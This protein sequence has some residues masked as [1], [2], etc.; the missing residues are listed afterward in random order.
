MDIF[1]EGRGFDNI[2]ALGSN[3]YPKLFIR[4]YLKQANGETQ[5]FDY[6]GTSMWSINALIRADFAGI[7]SDLSSIPIMD[8]MRPIVTNT[9]YYIRFLHELASVRE[10][11]TPLFRARMD[12]RVARFKKLL[13]D[14]ERIL[15]VRYQENA[16]GRIVYHDRSN[17]EFEEIGIFI[18]LVKSTYGCKNVSVIY[19]NLEQEGWNAT[20]D[21][22]SVKIDSLKHDHK[23]VPATI[24]SVLNEH[25]LIF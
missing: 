21:I 6:C 13:T 18:E 16:D 15:F 9:K 22:F 8:N 2:V 7:L 19:I 20:H 5:L 25:G 11:N 4:E 1:K 12:R 14:S 3:C 10:A 23:L 24:K 17:T